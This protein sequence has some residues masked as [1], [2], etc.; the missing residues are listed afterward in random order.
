MVDD[1]LF[2]VSA[3]EINDN[4]EPLQIA[5]GQITRVIV[6]ETVLWSE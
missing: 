3:L 4:A 1:L 6:L 5:M 2:Q